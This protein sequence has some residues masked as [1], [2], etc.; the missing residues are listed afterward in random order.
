MGTIRGGTCPICGKEQSTEYVA[1]LP[2]S[3]AGVNLQPSQYAV[4][5]GCYVDQWAM[6]YGKD[7]PCPI[8][9]ES[10]TLD[11]RRRSSSTPSD[12]PPVTS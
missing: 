2:T 4:C 7:V 10:S 8:E 6:A 9:T 11:K 5:P 1:L 12:D 3:R